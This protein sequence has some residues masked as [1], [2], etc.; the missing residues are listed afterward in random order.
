VPQNYAEAAKWFRLAAEQGD[1]A[2]QYFLAPYFAK[3]LGVPQDYVEA[4]MWANLAAAKVSLWGESRDE[5]ASVMTP[6][7][8]A[9]AQRL[10]AEWRPKPAKD[11]IP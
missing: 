9:E 1:E 4:Y 6:A 2:A 5:I 8:I 3:G 11:S 10:A 7:Q